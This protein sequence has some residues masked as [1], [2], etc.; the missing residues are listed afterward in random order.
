MH[1][2]SVSPFILGRRTGQTTL[3]IVKKKKSLFLLI[4]NSKVVPVSLGVERVMIMY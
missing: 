1:A 2:T 3:K 4:L